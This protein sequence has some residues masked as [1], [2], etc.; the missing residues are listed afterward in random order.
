MKYQGDA[1]AAAMGRNEPTQHACASVSVRR[2]LAP[3]VLLA[4]G[5][6]AHSLV[7]GVTEGVTYRAGDSEIEAR[8]APIAEMLSKTLKQPVTIKVLSTYGSAREALK[9]QQVELAFVHPAHVAFEATKG[10]GYKGLAWTAG[11]TEYKVSF[12]CK[13]MPSISSWKEIA[14]KTLVMPDPDSITSV[15]TRA[16]LREHG[17]QEGAV[18]LSS[19]RYQD[20]VPFYVQNGFA[21][22]GATASAGVVKAWQTSGGKTCAESRGVPI[23]QWL[24]SS[25]LDATTAA[26]VREALL[27]L[28]QSEG[29]KRALAASSYSGFVAPS[30]E[31]EKTLTAW[32]GI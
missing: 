11:F 20:A 17:L 6:S 8:F 32:L 19:T 21:A 3:L 9:Q 10:G 31:V 16:M 23:K 14:G 15:I 2:W 13:D 27:Q 30:V 25:K 26:T 28:G 22:Y 24:M 1:A 29:G 12:L 7:I 18:K 5:G 4:A